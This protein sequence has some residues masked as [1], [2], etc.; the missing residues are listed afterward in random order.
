LPRLIRRLTTE[1][2]VKENP[3]Y[4]RLIRRLTRNG[5]LRADLVE[6]IA[7]LLGY[8]DTAKVIDDLDIPSLRLH[9]LKGEFKGYWAITVR[10]NWRIIFRFADGTA[11]AVELIDYH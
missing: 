8:L 5:G 7:T 2:R 6:R 10:A 1:W 4:A 3:L 11:S 9:P